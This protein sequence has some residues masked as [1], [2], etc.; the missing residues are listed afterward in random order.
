MPYLYDDDSELAART[1]AEVLERVRAEGGLIGTAHL[2]EPFIR[3][4]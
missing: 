2:D 1:R 4:G 3:L